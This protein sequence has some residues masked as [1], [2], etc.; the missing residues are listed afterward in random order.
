[1]DSEGTVEDVAE[2]SGIVVDCSL[3]V[4]SLSE[5]VDS[6]VLLSERVEVVSSDF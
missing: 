4:I 3:S 2:S 1:M 5:T 6:I